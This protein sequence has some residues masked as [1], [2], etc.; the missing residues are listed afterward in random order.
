M[1]DDALEGSFDLAIRTAQERAKR[2][3]T[4]EYI[5]MIED[6]EPVCCILTEHIAR[7]RVP[8]YDAYESILQQRRLGGLTMATNYR[9][10]VCLIALPK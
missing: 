7:V 4:Y 10:A 1:S 2:M 6:D 8:G 5:E 3:R 9:R